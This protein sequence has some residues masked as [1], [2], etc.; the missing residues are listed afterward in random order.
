MLLILYPPIVKDSR[1][2]QYWEFIPLP[3]VA[4]ITIDLILISFVELKSSSISSFSTVS[5]KKDQFDEKKKF[6]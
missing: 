3:K 2:D 6:F 5:S 4:Y 1:F